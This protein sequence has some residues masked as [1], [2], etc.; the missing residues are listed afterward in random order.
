MLLLCRKNNSMRKIVICSFLLVIQ[1]QIFAQRDNYFVFGLGF[2]M[3]SVMDK[4]QSPLLY[5]CKSPK[6]KLG[7]ESY[8]PKWI[9]RFSIDFQYGNLKN[10]YSPDFYEEQPYLILGHINY[11]VNRNCFNLPKNM[12]LAPGIFI[13]L[14]TNLRMIPKLQNSMAAYEVFPCF[15]LSEVLCK[16]FNLG[17]R[18][19]T[20]SHSLQIPVVAYMMRSNYVS[21]MNYID[22]K[23]TYLGTI[24]SSGKLVT[25]NKLFQVKSTIDLQYSLSNNNQL[26]LSYLWDFYQCNTSN[27]SQSVQN[28]LIFSTMFNF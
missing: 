6:I 24:L 11:S 12:K 13:N 28:A 8:S 5:Q 15:G 2:S 1:L 21:M 25:I 7:Y 23:A 14:T 20:I 18:A 27:K 3:T 26:K 16:D 9:H 10:R 22:P 4:G 19:F 17:N